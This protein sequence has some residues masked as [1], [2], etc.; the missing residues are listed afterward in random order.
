MKSKRIEHDRQDIRQLHQ[1]ERKPRKLNQQASSISA[2]TSDIHVPDPNDLLEKQLR[3]SF[4]SFFIRSGS[5]KTHNQSWLETYVIGAEDMSLSGWRESVLAATLALYGANEQNQGAIAASY[6]WYQ[7]A[8][9][10]QRRNMRTCAENPSAQVSEMN[11]SMAVILAYSEAIVPTHARAFSQHIKAGAALL[12]IF[13]PEACMQRTLH[14]L[15]RTIRLYMVRS[16]ITL[17]IP[18]V[19]R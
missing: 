7:R 2:I 18:M 13:G 10:F 16:L 8:L 12:Q 15:F 1:P 19:Y 5:N 4:V 3:A 14:P 6:K 11:V 9:Y 17:I